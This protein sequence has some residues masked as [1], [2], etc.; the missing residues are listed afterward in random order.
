MRDKRGSAIMLLGF[1]FILS[2]FLFSIIVL[3]YMILKT[4]IEESKD[5]IDAACLAG[6]ERINQEALSYNIIEYDKAAVE[7]TFLSYLHDNI[8]EITSIPPE[9]EELE[10]YNR[11]D[12]PVVCPSGY[13]FNEPAIHIVI[14][15]NL[16][17][18]ALS[19]LLGENYNYRL[20]LDFGGVLE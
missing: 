6:L 11:E 4:N 15:V 1:L 7:A 8:T 16:T 12:L 10:V 14:R 20:H 3:D 19:G 13:A 9:I 18:P 17:R 2:F 5:A